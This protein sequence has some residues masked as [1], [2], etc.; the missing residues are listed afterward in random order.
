MPTVYFIKRLL[1]GIPLLL[2]ISFLAFLLVHAAPGGPFDRERNPASPEIK[3]ALEARYHLNEPL[4]KQYL[5]YLGLVWE[6]DDQG[7]W[8]RALAGFNASMRY[9]NHSVSDI[10]QQGLPVSMSL[11]ALSF[12]FA[13]GIG[14]PLGFFSAM[15]RGKWEDYVGSFLAISAVCVPALVLGPILVM[16]L[17]IKWR[18]F[19]V[20]LWS[21]PWHVVLPTVT[22]GLFF[23]GRIARLLREG[24]LNIFQAEFITAARAKGLDEFSILLKHAFR[25]A[26]LPV[27][28]Y[29]GPL[30]ADLLT[31]S[32]VIENIFQLPGIGLHLVNSSLNKDYPVVVGLSLVY[33]T[34][35]IVLN[36]LVDAAYALLDPRVKYG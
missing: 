21:S 35:L 5:R 2:V 7:Q 13:M 26:V 16:L 17:A 19:P 11:G 22:L 23:S 20:A 24:L 25:I 6:K 27:V 9:R 14:L 12:C 36:L 4:L 32:F 34:L 3:R 31:G 8:H 29:A 28:S 15:R 1:L 30:L 33:A 18:V 10:L